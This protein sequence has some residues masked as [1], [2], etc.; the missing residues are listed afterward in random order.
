MKI[1]SSNCSPGNAAR[2]FTLIELLVVIAIIAIL[3]ALL[4]PAL[5]IAKEHSKRTVCQSNQQQLDL[6]W[7]MCA[8]DDNGVL[9]LNDWDYR[10]GNVAESSSNSWV[11]GNAGLDTNTVSITGG[12]IYRYV[13]NVRTYR[14]PA[15]RSLVLGTSTLIL[16]TYSL[17][18]FMGGTQVDTDQWGIKPAHKMSEIKRSSRTLTFLDEDDATIDDGH[19]LY[20]PTINNWFNVPTWLHQKGVTLTFADGHGEYW[21]WRSARPTST[22]FSSGGALSDPVALQD[23]ARLQQ[24]AL[25]SN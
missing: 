24:T 3:A 5:S 22:Y 17:S 25:V 1:N 21:R 18:C 13:K 2:G 9:P 12:T 10:S 14:C 16:R 11:T 19:F 4:L 23:L 15:D 7:R 20:V 8:D 6:A